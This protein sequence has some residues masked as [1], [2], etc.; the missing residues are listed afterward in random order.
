MQA[1]RSPCCRQQGA[2]HV[3]ACCS[4]LVDVWLQ[5]AVLLCSLVSEVPDML[6]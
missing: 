6:P 5:V 3:R 2:E 4:R 1:L